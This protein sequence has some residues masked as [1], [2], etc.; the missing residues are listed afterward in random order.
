MEGKNQ[1]KGRKICCEEYFCKQVLPLLPKHHTKTAVT[2]LATDH[3]EYRG[4]P[5]MVVTWGEL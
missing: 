4:R 5:G 1:S 3:K 2:Y